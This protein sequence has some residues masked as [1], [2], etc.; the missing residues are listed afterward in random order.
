MLVNRRL[1]SNGQLAGGK[2]RTSCCRISRRFHKGHSESPF[3][4]AHQ[5]F[6]PT[7]HWS[8]N[9]WIRDMGGHMLT[10]AN[11][12][13][14]AV[15]SLAALNIVRTGPAE[16]MLTVP[17]KQHLLGHHSAAKYGGGRQPCCYPPLNYLSGRRS[18]SRHHCYS[19]TRLRSR[20]A[21][22]GGRRA[23]ESYKG[24]HRTGR[25]STAAVYFTPSE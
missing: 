25:G 22:P 23:P 4:L 6:W 7:F 18:T 5:R 24:D 16:F 20:N 15:C 19:D 8:A 21:T 10:R 11:Y 2:G 13:R 12:D 3:P 14:I 1:C 9:P 17:L